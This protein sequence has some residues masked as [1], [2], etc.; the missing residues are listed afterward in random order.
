M[1][2]VNDP[3]LLGCQRREASF[4]TSHPH[5]LR[6]T[7]QHTKLLGTEVTKR[8]CF[9][10]RSL[11]AITSGL[12]ANKFILLKCAHFKYR[13][14]IQRSSGLQLLLPPLFPAAPLKISRTGCHRAE[15]ADRP[16]IPG[17]QRLHRQ[18]G[19]TQARQ[20][21][22][23]PGGSGDAAPARPYLC[24]G[25]GRCRGAVPLPPPP[26]PAEHHHLHGGRP[27]GARRG[28][29]GSSAQLGPQL[30]EEAAGAA[31]P[32]RRRLRSRSLIL[33]L[34]LLL[35]LVSLRRRRRCSLSAV[36]RSAPSAAGLLT[37]AEHMS[38]VS[39]APP[40]PPLGSAHARPPCPPFPGPQGGRRCR[41]SARPGPAPHTHPGRRGRRAP[42]PAGGEAPAAPWLPRPAGGPACD[43]RRLPSHPAWRRPWRCAPALRRRTAA[44]SRAGAARGHGRR[45]RRRRAAGQRG[46][47]GRASGARGGA[48][49]LAGPWRQ[50]RPG[51]R[52]EGRPCTR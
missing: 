49:E 39:S 6:G 27:G 30:P 24:C 17:S 37:C 43:P 1:L 22:G 8:L 18:E 28:G 42:P 13:I 21:K 19:Q 20:W 7:E 3:V 48:A 36:L 31:P 34:L 4:G 47:V 23:R 26:P 50:R 15:R 51:G 29:G 35:L 45:G 16:R 9:P 11:L 10:F 33:L 52:G 25:G 38:R 40:P 5:L 46:G 12:S 41:R 44:G 32:A 14:L 2:L